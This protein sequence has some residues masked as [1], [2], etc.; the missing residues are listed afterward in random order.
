MNEWSTKQGNP[1]VSTS[2]VSDWWQPK[3]GNILAMVFLIML[4]GELPFTTA[5]IYF[6]PSVITIL[7]IGA[8][9]HLVNDWCDI[10][11]DQKAGKRNR[12]ASL[13][14][15]K[16]I[17]IL[18]LFLFLAFIPWVFLP[19]D[20]VS[21]YILAVEF[22]LLIIYAMPPIR[23][24]GR[25]I[26]GVMADGM[27]AYAVPTVLAAYT[28][29]LVGD[30]QAD[31]ILLAIV[32]IWQILA[33]IHGII[34]HQIEDY[35]NDIASGTK[36]FV[37]TKGISSGVFLLKRWVRI[38][39]MLSFLILV[40]YITFHHSY[41]Y[42]TG[43]I[44]YLM[45]QH[46]PLIIQR[47]YKRLDQD[48]HPASMQ[49]LSTTYFK[50]LPQWNILLCCMLLD[51]R[52]VVLLLLTILLI[53]E[54]GILFSRHSWL[55]RTMAPFL[56]EFPRIMVNQLIYQFRVRIQGENRKDA[57]RE[58]Y[59]ESVFGKKQTES[60]GTR[61]ALVNRN[62]NKYTETFVKKHLDELPF[63]TYFYYGKD[64]YFPQFNL[65]GHLLGN[66]IPYRSYVS[67]F[68]GKRGLTDH[69]LLGK[70]F[71]RDLLSNKIDVVLAEFGTTGAAIAPNVHNVGKPLVVIFHGYDA[72]NAKTV[73]EN[74]EQYQFLFE[75]ATLIIG[76]SKLL[77]NRLT[78]MGAPTFKLRHLPC[79]VDRYAFP[80]SDHSNNPPTFLMVGRL[81]STK[82]PHLSILAFREIL[83]VIPDA[84]L[85]IIGKDEKGEI[86]EFLMIMIRSL[87]M[88]E[89]VSFLGILPHEEVKEEME[90]A[91]VFIQHSVTTP[92]NGDS[93]GTPVAI[94]E[95][96]MSG[97]PV[98]ATRHSGIMDIIEHDETG[99]LV[100][101]HDIE[102]MTQHM[103]ALAQDDEKVRGIG[104]KASEF[105]GNYGPVVNHIQHLTDLIHEA[106]KLHSAK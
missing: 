44:L 31:F 57:F 99:L 61:L 98:I 73:E 36:T 102:T 85:R 5:F 92:I 2:R 101:E 56:L 10:P 26:L 83:K 32:F 95:A 46:L 88:E 39:E 35:A 38:L 15:T 19:W 55:Y 3:A 97:L 52:Y 48:D 21:V 4:I 66:F 93:E 60:F 33:G 14:I 12:M 43:P 94:M 7:G 20:E 89:H 84:K 23:L 53:R 77:L 40:G 68:L 69:F 37:T 42:A 64:A 63:D 65:S 74:K 8:F 54:P 34:I 25:A 100:D 81:A 9:G 16:R 104:K 47:I 76:V 11:S 91:R 49:L 62:A 79:G 106:M 6:F 41:W 103:I 70:A 59:N 80:Y 67:R 51:W 24:K 105:L 96:M 45:T 90:N 13:S 86:Q 58:H 87:G 78:Q 29:Y 50:F 1:I 75:K 71:E 30:A 28:F 22:L 17:L 18:V 27:Y 72:F 82:S